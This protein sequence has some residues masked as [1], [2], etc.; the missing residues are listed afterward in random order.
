MHG[1]S[2]YRLADSHATLGEVLKRAGY[3][4]AAF[5][6][7]F[8]VT[9]RF[10]LHQ[11]FDVFDAG[12]MTAPPERLVS[13]TGIVNT[14]N[15]QRRADATT[16]Q[17]LLW[18]AGAR[19][20]HFVWLHYFD[21]HDP[22]V[23]PPEEVIARHGRLQGTE[24]EVLRALYDIEIEYMDQHIRRVLDWLERTG[25]SE[26]TIV[27][28]VSDHG[29]GLGDHD[30]WTHGILYQEQVRV[31]LIIRTP[32]MSAGQRVDH[33]VRTIDIMPTVLDLIGLDAN[34][35]PT[36]EGHSLG[37]LLGE[38]PTDPKHVAY[39]DSVNT[40]TYRFTPNIRDL[41]N[42]ML[43]AVVSGPWKYIHHV[44][45]AD[46]SELYNLETDPGEQVNLLSTRP[47]LVKRL[48]ADLMA[49]ECIPSRQLS[50]QGGMS[51]E[52]LA[53]LR[54]LGYVGD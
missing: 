47:E 25:Q 6:S 29:E 26:K 40:S 45:H 35:I 42:E 16:D 12:F 30:W 4:T 38:R 24:R 51:P 10:G 32:S 2:E 41:K 49:R 33:L 31:P 13:K 19:S 44:P 8:P 9:E 21:P 7:A 46:R 43:F 52:D 14:G 54:S 23:L 15:N 11:G 5:V 3:E 34:A 18:L 36:M 39:C 1:R 17:A 48:K 37:P 53:R 20:P 22:K 28:V 50:E 27:V